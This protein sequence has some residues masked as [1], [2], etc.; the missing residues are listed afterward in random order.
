MQ[1]KLWRPPF[2]NFPDKLFFL[3]LLKYV[4]SKNIIFQWL[5]YNLD[6]KLDVLSERL[7]SKGIFNRKPITQP[8]F[9]SEHHNKDW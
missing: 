2:P 4:V 9:F 6:Q 3:I 1:V 8:D 5:N 7:F